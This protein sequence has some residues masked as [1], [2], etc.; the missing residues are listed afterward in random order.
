MSSV[1]KIIEGMKLIKEGCSE[2]PV[3]TCD[4]NNCP[5]GWYCYKEEIDPPEDWD[6]PTPWNK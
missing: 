3:G 1:E 4:C 5:F 6:I 2:I